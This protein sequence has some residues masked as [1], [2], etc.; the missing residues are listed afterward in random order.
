LEVNHH[1]HCN[2]I[3]WRVRVTI[4]AVETQQCFY[5]I[6]GMIFGKELWQLKSV[7]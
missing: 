6:N 7:Q 5:L 3:S 4:V 2:V 1:E